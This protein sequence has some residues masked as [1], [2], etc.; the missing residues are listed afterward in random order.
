MCS[1]TVWICSKLS[2]CNILLSMFWFQR[3]ASY[4]V[5]FF[6]QV[7]SY[8][9]VSD[10]RY[11]QERTRFWSFIFLNNINALVTRWIVTWVCRTPKDSHFPGSF[12][13]T[14]Y[15]NSFPCTIVHFLIYWNDD[16]AIPYNK[17]LYHNT[18][19][20]LPSVHCYMQYIN[21]NRRITSI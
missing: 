9:H 19:H 11:V 18:W 5:L 8:V 20:L 2:L 12:I 21:I 3:S 13:V 6:F 17:I 4:I 10:K 14:T 1:D 7:G 16:V 15:I